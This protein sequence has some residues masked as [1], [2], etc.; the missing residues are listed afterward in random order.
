MGTYQTRPPAKNEEVENVTITTPIDPAALVFGSP[1]DNESYLASIA[2]NIGIPTISSGPL[3]SSR[4]PSVSPHKPSEDDSEE[5]KKEVI[6]KTKEEKK[7]RT[8]PIVFHWDHG[9]N[10]IYVCG[11]FNN[12]MKIP[13]TRSRE[14][15]TTIVELPEGRH[16]YKFYVDGQW[17]HNPGEECQDNGL[18]TLNNIVNVSKKDFDAFNEV[19]D[20]SLFQKS[21][22]RIS[23]PGSYSQTIPPRSATSGLPPHLPSLLQQTVLNQDPVSDEHPALLPKP[24]HV[25]LNHLFALSIKDGVLVMATTNRYKEKYITTLMYKPV[26]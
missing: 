20:L 26:S 3:S 1:I 18:G 19:I 8:I 15:F 21:E 12:W 10:E 5:D 25:V 7:E 16:E 14:N 24:N 9:G 6:L 23:P 4:S 2:S 22:G 11:S 13:M 17:L